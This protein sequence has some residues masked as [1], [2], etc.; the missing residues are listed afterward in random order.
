MMCVAAIAIATVT[1]AA[2]GYS[3]AFGDANEIIGGF[4]Y[5]F[6]KDVTFEPLEGQT[7]PHL[8]FFAF[9]ATF[10][11][12][13]VALVSG[14]VVERM[15]FGAFMIFAALWSVLVYS[16]LAHW[17]FGP[18]W[19]LN[20]GTLDFAGGVAGGDGVGLLG[21]GGGARGGRAQGLRAP[22]AAAAQRGLRAAGRRPA[23][24]RLVR[25][26]RRQRLRHRREQRARVH[27]HA[28]HPRRGPDHL[29]RARPDP[30]PHGHGD[31]RG[32]GDHRR[33]RA[34]H[35]GRRLHQPG[36][37]LALGA[38][39]ALPCYA[40]V[41]YRPRTRVDETLDVLAA[42]GIAGFTGIL[43]IGFFANKSWNGISDGLFYGN[44]AQLWDQVLAAAAAPAYAFV[45]TFILLKVLGALMP[46][47]ADEKQESIGMDVLEHGE[48]AYAT[49]EGAILV[50]PADGDGK[51]GMPVA[52]P[53]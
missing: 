28:A 29:V 20:G 50:M 53:A 13:T 2:I 16:V 14:A 38:A 5:A 40:L 15:R 25:L 26:Q 27:Q 30:G 7:I 19:L 22:G 4:D 23:V 37:A 3:F 17:A 12:I 41:A 8:L 46:L 31:R 32:D 21:A 33:L 44:A 48:E 24:V 34:D 43:F 52:D 49:G 18:G 45:A 6:M 47:R 36:W 11:I 42:H 9:Q 10:C 1:W 39:G 35:P 51:A